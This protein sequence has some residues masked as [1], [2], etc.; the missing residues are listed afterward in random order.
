MK[1]L[2]NRL[3][4]VQLSVLLFAA[5]GLPAPKALAGEGSSEQVRSMSLGKT[6]STYYTAEKV[7]NARSNIEKYDWAKSIRDNAVKKAQFFLDLD[8]EFLWHFP[9]SQALPRSLG[10]LTRYKQ[11]VKGSPGPDGA[12]INKYGNYP[13]IIDPINHPWKLKSPVTGELY[14]TNDFKSYYESGLN[15]QGEF[16]PELAKINGSQFLKNELYP[17]RGENWG[18]DD[19]WGWKDADGD[20]WTFIAYYNH[21]AHWV[22]GGGNANHGYITRGLDALREAYLYTGDPK[23]AHKGLILLDRIADLYPDMDISVHHW[24]LGFDN[25]DPSVHTA[26]GKIVHDIWETGI[27]KSFTYAY[28]AFY[29]VIDQ[30]PELLSFLSSKAEQYKLGKSKNTPDDIRNN[31]EDNILRYIYPGVQNSQIRGNIGQHQSALALAAVVLDEEGTSKEWLDFVFKPGELIKQPDPNAPFGRKYILTGGNFDPVFYNDI[32][33]D[34]WGNEASPGYNMGWLDNFQIVADA[35]DGY[36]RYP[37]YDLYNNPKYLKMF[38]AYYPIIMLDNYTPTIGDTGKTGSPGL[39]GSLANDLIGFEKTEDPILAQLAYKRNGNKT[40][41]MHGSIFSADPEKIVRDIEEVIRTK[42]AFRLGS[43]HE[44]GFGFSAL[45]DGDQDNQ[46]GLWS[47]YGRNTGHGHLDTLNIGLHAFGIDLS[48][49]LGYPEVTGT[50]PER[51]NW[52]SATSSHNTVVVD[53]QSQKQ[54]VAAIPRHIDE[55]ETVK[56]LDI[57]APNVYPKTELYRRTTALIKADETN[58]YAIDF[59]RIKGGSDHVFSFHGAEG[60]AT[61]EGLE[62]VPQSGGSYAGADVPLKDPDYNKNGLLSGFNYLGR[63]ERDPDPTAAFSV[64]WS[65]KDTWNV[66]PVDRDIHMR[67]TMLGE[68]NDV[69]LADGVPPQN[70]PGNPKT[71]RYMLA[72]R[73]GSNLESNFTSVIEPYEN[74][75]FIAD[76]QEVSVKTNGKAATPLEAKAVKVTLLDGRIDYIVS[77]LNEEALYDVDDKFKFQGS[78]GMISYRDDKPV[79]TYMHDVSRLKPDKG[80]MQAKLPAIQGTVES[81]TKELSSQNEIVVDMK[82]N[83]GVKPEQLV[84]TFI[85]LETDGVRN[86]SYEIKSIVKTGGG[87]RYVIGIG[88]ITL[89][90]GMQ[91]KTD[92]SK[93]FVYDIAK[94]ASFTI[95]LTYEIR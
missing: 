50:D 45:R 25:G 52:T 85:H 37:E 67:L 21:W 63:V 88:D 79:Y 53:R 2:L 23:Y 24:D 57:E 70:K 17:E 35:V 43:T 26:Q 30:D 95:P 47:Y 59:F 68:T 78:F 8:D 6:K 84:G 86:A 65:L 16:D 82:L 60:T 55:T 11:R 27:V 90:R 28:D 39:I 87:H 62:M 75:R 9:T 58:S 33:R 36:E 54:Q 4:I 92:R 18:V 34:G 76:I 22:T 80:P 83:H 10:V 77:A 38:Q 3:V 89:I 81:F 61:V 7:T 12:E 19:G 29:P 93:G 5:S 20:V 71:L 64:D 40:T 49:D 72:H 73:S 74:E 1:P 15:E 42:G 41:G 44:T 66:H 51:L 32:D 56:L 13:W 69:A 91:D 14:P 48:P 31:I 46:R 94:G